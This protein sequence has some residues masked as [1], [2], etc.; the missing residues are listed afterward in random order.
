MLSNFF[1]LFILSISNLIIRILFSWQFNHKKF[2]HKNPILLA[3]HCT[4]WCSPFLHRDEGHKSKE[5]LKKEDPKTKSKSKSTLDLSKAKIGH[6]IG[7]ICCHSVLRFTH[8]F[9]I[10]A[11]V[12]FLIFWIYVLFFIDAK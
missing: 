5:A 2:N 10:D 1:H 4:F 8:I 11:K 7:L 3:A 9:T 12:L 6:W